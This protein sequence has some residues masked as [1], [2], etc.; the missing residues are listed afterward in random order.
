ME[1]LYSRGWYP[2]LYDSDSDSDYVMSLASK[3]WAD[4]NYN[5]ENNDYMYAC[6]K[7]Y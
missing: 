6:I 7:I 4:S 2:G 1:R 3:V 5:K